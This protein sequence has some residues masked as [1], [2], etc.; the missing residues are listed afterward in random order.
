MSR[1]PDRYAAQL[2]GTD[3]TVHRAIR[4]ATP[5]A[6]LAEGKFVIPAGLKNVST[7]EIRRRVIQ[8]PIVVV[9]RSAGSAERRTSKHNCRERRVERQGVPG[10][11]PC[12]IS[13][14]GESGG[15][16]PLSLR[17]RRC[18]A[19]CVVAVLHI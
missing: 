16:I 17:L 3:H 18:V 11:G 13:L 5:R 2:P 9:K 15:G 10:F 12:V 1:R 7:I 14:Y 8:L 6:I 19:R 4:I